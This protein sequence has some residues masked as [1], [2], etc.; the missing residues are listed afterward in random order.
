[1]MAITTRSSMRVKP[2]SGQ[3]W[4]GWRVPDAGSECFIRLSIVVQP[5]VWVSKLSLKYHRTGPFVNRGFSRMA[6]KSCH[7]K[8]GQTTKRRRTQNDRFTRDLGLCHPCRGRRWKACVI[9]ELRG[10]CIHRAS[11]VY[12]VIGLND[13][14]SS[15]CGATARICGM[16]QAPFESHA[17]LLL[18]DQP[19]EAGRWPE[20]QGMAGQNHGGTDGLRPAYQDA[21]GLKPRVSAPLPF[22]I[23]QGHRAWGIVAS[24][25]SHFYARIVKPPCAPV[26]CFPPNCS[27]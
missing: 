3:P 2:R 17:V 7:Q 10:L 13:S 22:R 24:T 27:R 18:F 11:S 25:N 16:V 21:V 23:G 8:W 4:R 26:R 9:L 20:N 19:Y 15:R 14:R 12:P 5:S 1:M 6:G